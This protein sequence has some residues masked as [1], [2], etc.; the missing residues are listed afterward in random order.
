MYGHSPKT[1]TAMWKEAIEEF[2]GE[3]AADKITVE[4]G[5]QDW[6]QKL[7]SVNLSHGTSGLEWT[8]R[9]V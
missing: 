1:F 2:E 5:L 6:V 4:V 3:G 8:V 9:R 7:G